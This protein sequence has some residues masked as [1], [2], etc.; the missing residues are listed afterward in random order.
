M[1]TRLSLIPL[2]SSSVELFCLL[3]IHT[4]IHQSVLPERVA[5]PPTFY[6]PS[7]HIFP[8]L[9]LSFSPECTIR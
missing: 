1:I 5:P 8:L 4:I 2:T 9:L 6:P 7:H 3:V